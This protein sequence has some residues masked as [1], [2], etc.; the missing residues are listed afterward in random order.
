MMNIKNTD[1]G[2]TLLELMVVIA[3]IAIVSIIGITSYVGLIQSS[4][5]LDE[6]HALKRDVALARSDAAT[7][8][9]NVVICQSNDPDS[10]NP[11]CSDSGNWDTG[12]VVIGT[13]SNT[14]CAAN[15]PPLKVHAGF[16][17]KNSLVFQAAN[18]GPAVSSLCFNRAGYPTGSTVQATPILA[19]LN[20][21]HDNVNDNV[22]LDIGNTG[23]MDILSHGQGGCS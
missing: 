2:L 15:G 16:Q 21:P 5:V 1:S 23:H 18:N 4:T 12:W 13:D 11:T 3:I 9:Q 6:I 7:A 22:C 17:S 19:I 14:S 20:T 10:A 8:G